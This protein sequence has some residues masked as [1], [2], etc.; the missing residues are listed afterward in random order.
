MTTIVQAL[1]GWFKKPLTKLSRERRMIVEERIKDWSRLSPTQREAKAKELDRQQVT[2]FS[3]KY[4]RA[5]RR[6]GAEKKDPKRVAWNVIGWNDGTYSL[7]AKTWWQTLN[8][9]P[10]N[11]AMLLCQLNSLRVTDVLRPAG[12]LSC[13]GP[14]R[15]HAPGPVVRR[16]FLQR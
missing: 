15:N 10:R 4:A 3:I 16:S 1:A 6:K 9:T 12:Y 14:E 13:I 7:D 2:K 11:A 5:L 8:V